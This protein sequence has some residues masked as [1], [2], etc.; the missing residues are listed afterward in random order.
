MVLNRKANGLLKG[1]L[2]ILIIGAGFLYYIG[3]NKEDEPTILPI[4]DDS[5]STIKIANWNLQIFGDSKASDKELIK[6]YQSK[7][8]DYDIIFIQEIRDADGSAFELLCKDLANYN[9]KISSRAGR[10]V[11]KEQ[12]GII[13]KKELR[14]YNFMD[15]NPD[16]SDRW[17]RPPIVTVFNLGT[18][19][20][21]LINI[22]IK[23]EDV[24]SE[25]N[26]LESFYY[27]TN[28]VYENIVLLGDLNADCS[29]YKPEDEPEFD[30]LK[31]VIGDEAD[32][33][34]S[35]TDCAYDRIIIND[36]LINRVV[37]SG[38]D[39]TITEDKSDHYIVWVELYK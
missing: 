7:I 23:P 20:L 19:N 14:M 25:L 28:V 27:I 8:D 22:H 38:I 13:Y 11:S 31:W 36:P 26:N 15:F 10:S 34:V 16:D 30:T 5:N 6:Y 29:Y 32:T 24:K 1:I 21:S 37:N 35:K 18:Y 33:T 17:E 2:I 4:L 9:C 39:K 12:Y 3:S